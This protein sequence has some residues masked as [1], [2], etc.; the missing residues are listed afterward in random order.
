MNECECTIKKNKSKSKGNSEER[1]VA[2]QLS[3]WFFNDINVLKRHPDSG[4]TK[5]CY[6]GDVIPMKQLINYWEYDWPFIVE[7]KTGYESF[8][9]T[10]YNYTKIEEWFI[11]ALNE[12]IENNQSIVL[13][14]TRFKGKKPLLITNYYIK[15]ILFKV[16]IPCLNID[17]NIIYTYVYDYNELLN[18]KYQH[19]FDMKE[20]RERS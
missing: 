10:F 7:V 8:S 9:P 4:A 19:I 6:C 18:Y 2:K 13:L 1:K 16:I 11:K 15:N 17:K 3:E 14:I 12:G 5:S 20:I